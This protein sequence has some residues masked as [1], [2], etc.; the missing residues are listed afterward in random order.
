MVVL[1]L[2]VIVGSPVLG[3]DDALRDRVLQLVER[4]EAPKLEARDAAETALIGLGPRALPFLPETAKTAGADLAQR[5]DRIRAAL[6]D[7][8]EKASLDGSKVTLQ[9]QGMRLSEVLQ[10]LQAQSGNPITDLRE[11]YGVDATNPTLDLEIVDRPL[12]EALDQV[13]RK[14][15][16]A[17]TFYTGDGTIGLMPAGMDR[18]IP[19]ENSPLVRYQGPF[20]IE[21]QQVTMVRNLQAGTASANLRLEVAWEPSL[22]PML[23]ALQ[24]DNLVIEDDQGK[25]IAPQVMEESLN[26]VLRPENP[27][28]EINLNMDAP[29]RSAEALGRVKIQAE[30]TV[31]AAT[32][33]FRFAKLTGPRQEQKQDDVSVSLLGTTV[34]EANWLVTVE[35]AYPGG[36]PAFESYQQGLFNN[37]VYLQKPDGSVF[38][39]NGG[40]NQIGSGDSRVAFEY[41]F[42]DAPGKPDDYQLVYETPSKVVT[43]PL[44]FELKAIPL[45]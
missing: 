21:A 16:V 38:D 1:V 15:G 28:A 14:A 3:Q 18:P 32:K 29:P 45:P 8:R 20:R 43:I 6:R 41:I 12:L 22:R 33:T 17:V 26:V 30:V 19:V 39:Q 25:T 7:A 2:I 10:A 11:Q 40:F 27:V 42:V 44:E 35:V 34:D 23:L 9:A 5:L 36:G 4:L 37:R 31:P 13:A 24:A